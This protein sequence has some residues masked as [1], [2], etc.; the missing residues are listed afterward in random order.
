MPPTQTQNPSED[1]AVTAARPAT[2]G[3][4][5]ARGRAGAIDCRA[6]PSTRGCWGSGPGYVRRSPPCCSGD[7]P[8]RA[9]PLVP[10]VPAHPSLPPWTSST[11]HPDRICGRQPDPQVGNV[12]RA[13]LPRR[14]AVD[15]DEPV[16]GRDVDQ[17]LH[18]LGRAPTGAT[19][20]VEEARRHVQVEV[21]VAGAI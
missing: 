3:T 17:A 5:R 15:V 21:R 6:C 8:A 11:S 7:R 13:V 14:A 1:R 4:C 10:L 12:L 2:L 16:L 9:L 19:P 20:R 18:G